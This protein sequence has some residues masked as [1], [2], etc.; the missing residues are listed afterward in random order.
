MASGRMPCYRYS[1]SGRMK[2]LWLFG[3]PCC[4]EARRTWWKASRWWGREVVEVEDALGVSC[5][6]DDDQRGD[7][8]VFHEGEGGGGEGA[9]VDRERAGVHDL[10]G[11]VVE[12]A[13]AV[14]LE[15]TAEVAVGDHTEE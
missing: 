1:R 6:I 4:A 9:G 10:G 2:G 14:A 8:P 15:E 3:L 12:G 5:R 11:G 13:V 7:L